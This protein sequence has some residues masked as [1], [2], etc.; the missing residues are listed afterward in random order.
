[1]P[2]SRA[3]ARAVP[4][5][6]APDLDDLHVLTLQ[7]EAS[8]PVA[9]F[10]LDNLEIRGAEG[11]SSMRSW[12]LQP[13]QH[14]ELLLPVD[15]LRDTWIV[16]TSAIVERGAQRIV[17]IAEA[18]GHFHPQPV[19][20]VAEG[21]GRAAIRGP[22]DGPCELVDGCPIVTAGGYALALA[23][24]GDAAAEHHHDH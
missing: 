8:G 10:D 6:T 17:F 4:A 23:M 18:G 1:M 19:I 11:D 21:A 12:A 2:T 9:W 7:F 22:T 24:R 20:V 3:I 15:E 16:P 14:Y 5:G 13:G